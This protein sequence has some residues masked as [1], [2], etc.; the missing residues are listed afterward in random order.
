MSNYITYREAD[1]GGQLQYFILQKQWPHYVG[2]VIDNPSYKSI[3]KTPIANTTLYVSLYG[4]L[5]G[6]L[7]PAYAGVDK[8]IAAIFTDMA[9]WFYEN[10]ILPNQKKY[11]KWLLKPQSTTS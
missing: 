5:Q 2:M 8:E 10:R 4:T 11:N 7:L 6:R 9:V 1:S 3:L